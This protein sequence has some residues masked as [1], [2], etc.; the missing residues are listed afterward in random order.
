MLAAHGIFLHK[1]TPPKRDNEMRLVWG[2]LYP[3]AAGGLFQRRAQGQVQHD[4]ADCGQ[5][6]VDER[7]AAGDLGK[8]R[9]DLGRLAENEAVAEIA[10]ERVS[11]HV[12]Q[13]ADERAGGDDQQILAPVGGG[14]VFQVDD[15]MRH[16]AADQADDEL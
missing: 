3:W 16:K 9:G 2:L 15:L 8:D 10:D 12:D 13:Q 1:K 7:N 11:K 4:R 14:V 6:R 5:Q